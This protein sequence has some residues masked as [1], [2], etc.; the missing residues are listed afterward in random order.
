MATE[1]APSAEA[2]RKKRASYRGGLDAM[3]WDG[4]IVR[5]ELFTRL[6][7][8]LCWHRRTRTEDS[9]RLRPLTAR[10]RIRIYIRYRMYITQSACH[11]ALAPYASKVKANA[12]VEVPRP[13]AVLAG[14]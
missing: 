8:I 5:E 11:A 14:D 1:L 13:T 2:S 4:S 12:K 3:R 7:K 9:R 10:F 6:L